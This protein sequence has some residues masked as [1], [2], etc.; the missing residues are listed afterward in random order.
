M[1]TIL[2]GSETFDRSAWRNEVIECPQYQGHSGC[3]VDPG[4]HQASSTSLG[5]PRCYLRRQWR[6]RVPIQ[7]WPWRKGKVMECRA[8][9]SG[10]AVYLQVGEGRPPELLGVGNSHRRD[11]E[12]TNKQEPGGFGLTGGGVIIL[13]ACPHQR[14]RKEVWAV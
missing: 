2:V 9:V 13:T 4:V 14:E 3:S 10:A 7:W 6:L 8:A 1:F 5:E 11:C 12:P